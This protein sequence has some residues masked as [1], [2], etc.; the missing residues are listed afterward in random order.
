MELLTSLGVPAKLKGVRVGLPGSF[1]DL[2][3]DTRF[4][5]EEIGRIVRCLLLDTDIGMGPD[6]VDVVVKYRRIINKKD[7]TRLRV[8]A[9]RKRRKA[10]GGG[11]VTV[12]LEPKTADSANPPALILYE[13]T[14]SIF[15][16]NTPPIVPL[17]KKASS[18]L[19]KKS[20]YSS[21][22]NEV[23]G[24]FARGQNDLFG[25]TFTVDSGSERAESP[26]TGSEG[27]LA[28]SEGSGGRT[29]GPRNALSD[30][31]IRGYFDRFWPEY[32]KKVAKADA[33]KAFT[34]IIRKQP[35][36]D[37]FMETL[38]A[39]LEW[40]KGQRQWTK[41]KGKFIPN[42]ATWLN[43]G[44]WEDIKDNESEGSIEAQFLGGDNELDKD[45]IRRMLGGR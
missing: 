36:V 9:L 35:D 29:R 4:K 27:P 33:I 23:Q 22:G 44:N 25:E 17:K 11:G 10:D 45:L 14:P 43:K 16:E 8:A 41:D 30:N 20:S 2:V 31:V 37:K 40:W 39:S 13:K 7:K 1:R 3:A 15:K 26:E 42:P 28:A 5:N 24:T 32:P 38:L 12:T 6:I 19:E 21:S 34:K 18:F